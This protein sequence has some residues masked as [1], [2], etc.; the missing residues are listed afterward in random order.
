MKLFDIGEKMRKEVSEY[1]GMGNKFVK[2]RDCFIN[3]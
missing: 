3:G 1:S 2:A